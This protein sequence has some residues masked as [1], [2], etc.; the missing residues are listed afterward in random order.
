M[1]IVNDVF[2]VSEELQGLVYLA[3][4]QLAEVGEVSAEVQELLSQKLQDQEV[5]T[6]ELCNWYLKTENRLAGLKEEYK[7]IEE[8]IKSD[9]SELE[10]QLKRIE[11]YIKMALP[12]GEGNQIA[13]ESV[14]AFY[15][16]SFETVIDE[17]E[18]VP[19]EFI[20]MVPKI[21]KDEIKAALK[22]G[23]II[24]GARL[25][26]NFN[27]QVKIGGIRAQKAAKARINKKKL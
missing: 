1:S 7:P 11:K 27:L 8:K 21:Q 3:E 19:I 13:N 5:T 22:T 16:P 24:P 23:A 2:K 17:P 14:Y 15:T 20:E 18:Y 6:T 10:D 9:Y 12:P 25:K 4:T 26:E